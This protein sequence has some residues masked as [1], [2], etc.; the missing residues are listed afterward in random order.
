MFVAS[1]FYTHESDQS[2]GLTLQH[3]MQP[4]VGSNYLHNRKNI[5]KKEFLSTNSKL[6]SRCCGVNSDV[7]RLAADNSFIPYWQDNS[8]A[9]TRVWL[10]P[11]SHTGVLFLGGGRIK[12]SNVTKDNR[13]CCV[14]ARLYLSPGDKSPYPLGILGFSHYKLHNLSDCP[15]VPYHMFL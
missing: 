12:C 2:S 8:G 9:G 7:D 11:V 3:V 4:N 1:L 13:I 5:F 10:Q 6:A 15:V 14:G